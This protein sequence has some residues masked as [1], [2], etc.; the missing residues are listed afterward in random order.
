MLLCERIREHSRVPIILLGGSHDFQLLRD[1]IA[2]QV[3]D[4][5]ADPVQPEDWLPACARSRKI[6]MLNL[7]TPTL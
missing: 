3:S 2:F 1:A 6:S 7:F 4:Y 5:I